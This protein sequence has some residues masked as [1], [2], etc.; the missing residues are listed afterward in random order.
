MSNYIQ[1]GSRAHWRASAALFLGSFVTFAVLYCTQPLIPLFSTEF[2]TTPSVAS[3]SVSMATGLLAFCMILMSWASDAV[4]RKLIMAVALFVAALLAIVVAFSESFALLLSVRA[5]QGIMLAGFPAIAMAYINEEFDPSTTGLVMGLY[6]SG[7]SVG[8]ML[9]RVLVGAMTDLFSWRW[10]IAIIGVVSLIVSIWFWFGLPNSRNFTA[11]KRPMADLF[12]ALARKLRDR[13]LL[14]LFGIGFL[15]QGGFVTLYNY[16][17]YTLMAPPYNLSQTVVGFI[18]LVYLTGTFSST[19]MGRLADRIGSSRVLATSLAIMLSGGLVTL[20]DLLVIKIAG[21]AIFTFGFFGSHSVA[22]SSVGRSAKSDKAQASSLY[23]LFYY[24]GSSV[25][26]T[27]GGKFLMLYGWN[28]I[29]GYITTLLLIAL[30]LILVPLLC[31]KLF[32]IEEAAA[33][34]K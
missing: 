17:G 5:L 15:I 21:V 4:G 32:G 33:E 20:S 23:L 8:G 26:G 1:Q 29:V 22:S 34:N 19:L 18:F 10:A 2:G 9:G 12:S 6:V 7:T 31:L 13:G 16:I 11:K 25:L 24:L 14:T 30:L 27:L 3:L 28:G